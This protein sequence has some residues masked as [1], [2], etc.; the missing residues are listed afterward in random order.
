MTK[1]LLSTIALGKKMQVENSHVTVGLTN[2]KSPSNVG[3]VMRAA[4]CYSVEQVF[5]TGRRYANAA[6]FNGEK[7]NTDTKNAREKIPLTAVDDFENIK[8]GF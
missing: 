7:H 4:G 6:K 1:L 3:A 5:F 8:I 2:P